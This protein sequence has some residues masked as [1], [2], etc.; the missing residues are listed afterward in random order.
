M[1]WNRV[2]HLNATKET[3]FFV[4]SRIPLTAGLTLGTW[5]PSVR[6]TLPF[7]LFTEFWRHC[8]LDGGNQRRVPACYKNE[9]MRI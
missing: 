7:P 2:V 4:V 3:Y 9:K 8:V 6:R 5:E 1:K